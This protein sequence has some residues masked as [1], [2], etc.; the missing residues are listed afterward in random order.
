LVLFFVVVP[1]VSTVRILRHLKI[2]TSGWEF[3]KILEECSAF[4]RANTAS[5]SRDKFLSGVPSGGTDDD[6]AGGTGD[7][8]A[9]DCSGECII[10]NLLS[11]IMLSLLYYTN[12]LC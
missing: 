3:G 1:H 5:P 9:G 7:A 10:Y 8:S 6:A 4:A 12:K 11:A 2:D